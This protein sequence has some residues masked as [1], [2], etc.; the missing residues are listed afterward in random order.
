LTDSDGIYWLFSA[1]N[2]VSDELLTTSSQSD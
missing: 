2:R 1:W